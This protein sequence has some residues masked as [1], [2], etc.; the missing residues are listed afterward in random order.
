MNLEESDLG[1]QI[2]TDKYH[3]FFGNKKASIEILKSK[4]SDYQ[5]LRVKQTHSSF[6]VLASTEVKEADAHY[7]DKK[8]LALV[9]STADC[10][11]ILIHDR[12]SNMV[13]SVHAGWKGVANKILP[14]A[15]IE[16]AKK[17]VKI[18]NCH[19]FVG[20]HILQKSFEVEIEVKEQLK[21]SLANPS[22]FESLYQ[23]N[24]IGN[25]EKFYVNL[26]SVLQSQILDMGGSK[27][28]ITKSEID[29]KTNFNW[30]S[31]RRDKA[32]SGRNISFIVSL[33]KK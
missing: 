27:A 30:H 24:Q 7:T 2:Q 28:Q 25:K 19:F 6:V 3:V 4:F 33:V 17:G 8:N 20:P 22:D 18:E 9:V 32:D 26:Q 12:I 16:F 5:F 11:P 23:S 29:T 15:I 1:L 13:G 14:N 21:Q 31:F 10:V